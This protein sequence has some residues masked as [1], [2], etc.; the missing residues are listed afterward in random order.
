[1][2]SQIK[3]LTPLLT[4]VTSVLVRFSQADVDDLLTWIK[5]RKEKKWE[6]WCV[7]REKR[8]QCKFAILITWTAMLTAEDD[9]LS[10][11]NARRLQAFT[12]R[13]RKA[14]KHL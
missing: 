8:R 3:I 9:A 7:V 10:A 11:S 1:M 6:T 13:K 5:K 4:L 2:A 14:G 12:E